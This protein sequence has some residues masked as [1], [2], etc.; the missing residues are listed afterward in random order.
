MEDK[1]FYWEHLKHEDTLFSNRTSFFLVGESILLAGVVS[2]LAPLQTSMGQG[3]Q[4]VH[5]PLG[6]FCLAGLVVAIV[7]LFANIKHLV[8]SNRQIKAKLQ[9]CHPAWAAIASGRHHWPSVN[10]IVGLVLPALFF[11][12]WGYVWIVNASPTDLDPILKGAGRVLVIVGLVFNIAGVVVT[13]ILGLPTFPVKASRSLAGDDAA[14]QTPSK[15]WNWSS[16]LGL[17]LL[18]VGFV[19]QLVGVITGW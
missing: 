8:T 10:W 4:P 13:A 9:D 11:F 12:V 15:P 2:F 14:Q 1:D 3:Q 5:V 7:W 6:P 18:M 19:V 17:G 16:V